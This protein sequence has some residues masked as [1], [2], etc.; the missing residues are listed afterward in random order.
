MNAA[1][2]VKKLMRK[3]NARTV[4]VQKLLKKRKL[5]KSKLIK[6][7][8]MVKNMFSMARL[9]N[10]QELNQVMLLSKLTNNHMKLSREK[11]L[12]Y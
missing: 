6:V 3:I 8:H 10:F 12:I 2:L 7:L 5:S 11:E 1:V 9:M 4:M